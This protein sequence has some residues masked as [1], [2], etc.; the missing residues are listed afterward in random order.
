MQSILKKTVTVTRTPSVVFRYT[1]CELTAQESCNGKPTDA[2]FE[3]AKKDLSTL[4]KLDVSY[5]RK[6]TT[7]FLL[8]ISFCQAL[9][10]KLSPR[11]TTDQL[12]V[13]FSALLMLLVGL[14]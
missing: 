4:M 5:C 6:K 2:I 11:Y 12:N 10:N 13:L 3:A 1:D 14:K 8:F 9:E 7:L